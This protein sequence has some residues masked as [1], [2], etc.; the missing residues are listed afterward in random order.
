MYPPGGRRYCYL[1][2]NLFSVTIPG[3][4]FVHGCARPTLIWRSGRML[5]SLFPTGC[6]SLPA[7]E[8]V[9]G[10]LWRK[11]VWNGQGG[12]SCGHFKRWSGAARKELVGCWRNACLRAAP[13]AFQQVAKA[14]PQITPWLA[15]R[16][17]P[18]GVLRTRRVDGSAQANYFVSRV[19]KANCQTSAK[20]ALNESEYQG[21]V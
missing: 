5:A 2:K 9:A 13:W 7:S 18:T 14:L 4:N 16:G 17:G 11:T 12:H 10:Q 15:G 3:A 20:Q 1:T 8:R 6:P 19:S 21:N